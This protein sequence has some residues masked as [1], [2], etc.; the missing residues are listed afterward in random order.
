MLSCGGC[1]YRPKHMEIETPLKPFIP[2][3]VPA[4]G[5]IDEFIKVSSSHPPDLPF[6][7]C[8]SVSPVLLL[9]A[10]VRH[11]LQAE[12]QSALLCPC[13]GLAGTLK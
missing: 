1:R 2:E 3:Y 11:S 4:T 8:N 12:G 9:G 7:T 13:G 6:T 5:D 10:S